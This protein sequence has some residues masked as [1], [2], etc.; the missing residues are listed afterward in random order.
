MQ[1]RGNER[2]EYLDLRR[3]GL[4]GGLDEQGVLSSP[5]GMDWGSKG[6]QLRTASTTLRGAALGFA[7]VYLVFSAGS[8]RYLDPG[9]RE[10]TRSAPVFHTQRRPK[11]A[12]VGKSSSVSGAPLVLFRKLRKKLVQTWGACHS[13]A[14]RP[15][16]AD[17]LPGGGFGYSLS[18]RSCSALGGHGRFGPGSRI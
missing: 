10:Q 13:L 2:H 12:N 9:V 11:R 14:A 15:M 5:A 6:S 7:V 3:E 16:P 1:D 17:A 18:G 4:D 8:I